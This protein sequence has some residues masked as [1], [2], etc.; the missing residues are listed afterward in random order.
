MQNQSNGGNPPPASGHP[1][2]D[3]G[4]RRDFAT[5]SRRDKRTG[6]GRFDLLPARALRRLARHFEAGAVKYGDRNWEKGQPLSVYLDSALRHATIYMEGKT[7][8]DHLIAAA[9]NLLCLADTEERIK[10]GL[11]PREL[12]DLPGEKPAWE[13]HCQTCG[14]K[15]YGDTGEPWLCCPVCARHGWNQ[16]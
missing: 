10:E 8:E 6:K 16:P 9:W 12:R 3:S 1:L 11:L 14:S 4:E 7:D 15:T 5:G 13:Y 2:Q